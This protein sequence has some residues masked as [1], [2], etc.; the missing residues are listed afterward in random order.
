MN[1]PRS[2]E[3]GIEIAIEKQGQS[4]CNCIEG[5]VPSIYYLLIIIINHCPRKNGR[6]N[7]F[8]DNHGQHLTR[9]PLSPQPTR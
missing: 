3:I 5:P 7:L 1:D 9:A 2:M 4:P 8:V 6:G